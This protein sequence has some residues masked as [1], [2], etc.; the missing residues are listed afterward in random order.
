MRFRVQ[1]H[2]LEVEGPADDEDDDD[3]DVNTV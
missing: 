2:G 1:V 3:E